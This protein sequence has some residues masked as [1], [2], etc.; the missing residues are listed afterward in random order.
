MK[1]VGK[2]ILVKQAKTKEVSEGGIVMTAASIQNLPYGTVE[3]VGPRAGRLCGTLKV[4][5]VVLFEGMGAIPL[6]IKE[7]YVLIEPGD[8][9]AVL[10]EGEF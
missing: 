5:D 8:I 2:R 1:V 6:R 4:G 9:L 10:E 3:Q 7:G